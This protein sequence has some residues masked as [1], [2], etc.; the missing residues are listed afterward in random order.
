MKLLSSILTVMI[1]IIGAGC[2]SGNTVPVIPAADVVA[3]TS[4]L[5]SSH[6]P[7]GFFEMSVDPIAGTLDV[8]VLR[9]A[10]FHL[11]AIHYVEPPA[12]LHL[13][14]EGPPVFSGG[15]LDV[16]I[17]LRHP[18]LGL[19][20][21]TGFDVC[22]ILVTDGNISG[23]DDADIVLAGPGATRLLN[24]DG[25][26]RWW[27]PREFPYNPDFEGQGYKDGLL[28]TPDETAM[29]SATLNGYK[30]YADAMEDV[31]T[32]DLIDPDSRGYFSAGQKNIRHY[33]ISMESGLVFNYA[34]D[35]SWAPTGVPP[36]QIIVP[37]SFKPAANRPEPFYIKADNVANSLWYED[38]ESGGTLSFDVVCYDWFDAGLLTVKAE[39]PGVFA[40]ASSSMPIDGG[41][42]F[43]TYHI[44]LANPVLAS[45]DDINVL[46]YAESESVGYQGIL[47]GEPITGYAPLAAFEVDDEA[48]QQ[49]ALVWHDEGLIISEAYQSQDD[50]EPALTINGEGLILLSYFWFEQDSETHWVNHPMYNDSSD[51]ALTFGPWKVGQWQY[52]GIHGEEIRCFNGKFTMGPNG[53]AWHSYDAPCG[54]TLHPMPTFEP[55]TEAASHSGTPIEHAGEMLYTSEGYPMMFGDNGGVIK[56]RRGDLPNQGGTGN[57]PTYQGTEY[58]LVDEGWLSLVRST[59]KTSDGI[60]RL[61][62]WKTG[63]DG[64]IR[65]LSSDDTTGTSWANESIIQDG[66]AE[67]WVGA[68]DP[69]LWIDTDDGFH[70]AYV[71]EYWW[72][73]AVP[74]YAYSSDGVEWTNQPL[75]NSVEIDD[76]ELHDTGVIKM[77]GLGEDYIFICYEY[78]GNIWCQY[79]PVGAGEF[80]EP[81]QVNVHENASIPDLY[82]NGGDG[83]V[84]AYEAD[85]DNGNRDIFYRMCE[86]VE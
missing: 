56:M 73:A 28:G 29:Y 58:Q 83:V 76:Y 84:W 8:A 41:E 37:D 75:G 31:L 72:D 19:T 59:G 7:L 62:Y 3:R 80:S 81:I 69:S 6:I 25:L 16:D 49:G 22:G 33:T 60:C 61:A 32:P 24:A 38:S 57:W 14:L 68:H 85:G 70:C 26:T 51:G 65:M 27:N 21:Y 74:V 15:K 42:N 54:H 2:S 50:I 39:C 45:A 1:I 17:G 55:Y 23:Y 52:H 47:P 30:Y 66:M 67:I 10:D 40:T 4:V 79:K 35:A 12:N 71:G 36:G 20:Q 18:L 46:I 34:I 64:P 48:P 53:Q 77:T 5:D 78:K 44:D 86:F 82:P 63:V 43:S 11:N 13:T 9:A